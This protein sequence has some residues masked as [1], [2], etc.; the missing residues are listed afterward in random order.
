MNAADLATPTRPMCAS[1]RLLPGVFTRWVG[2]GKSAH[3]MHLCAL[4]NQLKKRGQRPL[5]AV[6]A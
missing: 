6:P 2:K 3:R 1:C 5:K 4:C